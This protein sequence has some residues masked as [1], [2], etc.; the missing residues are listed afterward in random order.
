MVTGS[1]LGNTLFNSN[2][3]ISQEQH[4]NILLSKCSPTEPSPKKLRKSIRVR[5]KQ[6][7]TNIDT[8]GGQWDVLKA[9]AEQVIDTNDNTIKYGGALASSSTYNPNVFYFVF[10]W[11]FDYNNNKMKTWQYLTLLRFFVSATTDT[12]NTTDNTYA[13]TGLWCLEVG[14][15]PHHIIYIIIPLFILY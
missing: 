4:L 9:Q 5:N 2:T 1:F 14:M 7:A 8:V 13:P 6:K 11:W 10:R 12:T 3:A 15:D